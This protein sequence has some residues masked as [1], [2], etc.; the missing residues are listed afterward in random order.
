M[1]LRYLVWLKLRQAWCFLRHPLSA[2]RRHL[3]DVTL[4]LDDDG[5]PFLLSCNRCYHVSYVDPVS[6]QIFIH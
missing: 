4:V 1:G 5:E 3:T 2:A 6:R